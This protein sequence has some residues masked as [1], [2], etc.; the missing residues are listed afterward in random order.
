[1]TKIYNK[2]TILEKA[3]TLFAT[4]GPEG[5]SMRKLA[6]TIPITASVLYHYFPTQDVLL[7]NMYRFSNTTLG[8][9]RAALPQPKSAIAMLKQRLEFQIEN[10]ELIVAVLK[11]YLAHRSKFKKN[12]TGFVPDKSALHIEEVLEFGSKTG[13]FVVDD[14]ASEAKVIAHAVNGFLLE[15]HP[16]KPVGK[17]KEALIN[18]MSVFIVKA[19]KGGKTI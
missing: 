4:Y 2:T 6:K 14:I 18:Q 17:E 13:E 3:V 11:Y 8:A 19:L 15:Y 10:Q 16:H 5:F 12:N 7:E 9:K 1:M